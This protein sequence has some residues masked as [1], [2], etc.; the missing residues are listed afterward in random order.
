M[1]L[2][3]ATMPPAVRRIADRFLRDP[4]E[5]HIEVRI[6]AA[7]TVRQRFQ[8]VRG[9]EKLDALTRILEVEPF[10][11]MLVFVRTRNA[12]TE[13]AERLEARGFACA[14]LSGEIPQN[15]RE[16]T[17][18]RLKAREIN[19]LVATDVA[20]RGLDVDRISHVVNY[21]IPHDSESYVHRIGRTGRAG[22]AGE[23]ILFVK[24][25]ERGMLRTLERT[26]GQPLERMAL[27]TTEEVNRIRVARFK[28][29]ILEAMA[30]DDASSYRELIDELVEESEV[31][32][33]AVAA[34]LARLV[35][36]DVPLF[37]EEKADRHDP[38][39]APPRPSPRPRTGSPGRAE[40]PVRMA[41]YRI[42]I[43]SV[44]GA[45]PADIVRA[46]DQEAGLSG[47]HIGRIHILEDHSRIELPEDLSGH[48]RKAIGRLH[49]LGR[50]LKLAPWRARGPA[51][52]R[53]PA[54]PPPT[55]AETT[56]RSDVET[57]GPADADADVETDG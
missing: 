9:W 15:R 14:P 38:S 37:L 36:G 18:E 12:T 28:E 54:S 39:T 26:V 25:R 2:F 24:P 5:I 7:E 57:D 22:R 50:K 21:D 11:A 17:L 53:R 51:R 49:V 40:P 34:A 41:P 8:V 42:E 1:A 35:Q 10:D 3:S 44:H 23:A 30:I 43:G 45:G 46:I 47:R 32:P 20:A 29:R 56:P 13:I 31:D 4:E 16:R 27:P 52:S 33:A 6:T 48:Y 19:I 55:P